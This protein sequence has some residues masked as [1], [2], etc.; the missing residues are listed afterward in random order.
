MLEVAPGYLSEDQA[1]TRL[2]LLCEEIG[3]P[4]DRGLAARR[5]ALTGGRRALRGTVL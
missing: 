1:A 2:A 3:E 4:F 5:F